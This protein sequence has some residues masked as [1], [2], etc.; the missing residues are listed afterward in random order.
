MMMENN[1]PS[2][3][4]EFITFQEQQMASNLIDTSKKDH[5]YWAKQLVTLGV[6]DQIELFK[7]IE[8]S[9]LEWVTKQPR[10]NEDTRSFLDR[11]AQ[12]LAKDKKR[13]SHCYSKTKKK[14][15]NSKRKNGKGK[16]DSVMSLEQK[17]AIQ[18]DMDKWKL[19]G[20]M[21]K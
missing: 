6:G 12:R 14:G 16:D 11:H 13:T 5:M 20:Q 7:R 19:T 15:K 8:S 1:G 3:A 9:F 4:I 10:G 18:D 2:H 17:K 21:Q